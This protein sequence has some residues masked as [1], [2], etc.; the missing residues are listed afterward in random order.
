MSKLRN[1][2]ADELNIAYVLI[3]VPVFQKHFSL[4]FRAQ[5]FHTRLNTTQE[6]IERRIQLLAQGFELLQF[7]K[8]FGNVTNCLGHYKLCLDD[9]PALEA[10]YDEMQEK[11]EGLSLARVGGWLDRIKVIKLPSTYFLITFT[12]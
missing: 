8:F 10:F 7:V 1:S 2:F 6:D 3:K 4:Q 12:F 5:F 9:L 11:V